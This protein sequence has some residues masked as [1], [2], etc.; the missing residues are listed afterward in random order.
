MSRLV[1][2]LASG[3]VHYAW[4][5][6]GVA[7]LTL[8]VAAGI[9]NAPTVL[10]LPLEHEFG[11]SATL[12]SLPVSVGLLLYGAVGPFSA[13]LIDRF[14]FRRVMLSALGLTTVGFGL[15][16]FVSKPWQ[17]L[18]LW[19][20]LTGAGTG[21]TALVMGAVVANRWFLARRGLVIGLLT[22]SAAAGQLLFV[23]PLDLLGGALGWRA[24]V[25]IA[26]L[27]PL[28][29]VP[30]VA[31]LMRDHPGDVGLAP[32]GDAGPAAAPAKPL[33]NPLGAVL[34]ALG[35]ALPSRDFWLLAASFFVCGGTT[36]GLVGTH[37]I[38]ACFDHGIAPSTAAT[39]IVA[40]G[41]CNI[42]GT[43]AS[44]WL[45][46]RFD[47]R[48][49]L[50]WY[51]LLR[52]FSLLFLPYAL[53]LSTVG[54]SLFGLFY[55]LDWIATVPPTVRLAANIF[56]ARQAGMIYG[57][58]TVVH[59]VGSALAASGAALVRDWRGD[60][61]DAFLIAGGFCFAAALLVLRLGTASRG[62][63]R[64]VLAEAGD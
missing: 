9:R 8:L 45:S 56:G 63:T 26:C 1:A 24:A 48:Y 10:L 54:M 43:T 59:Q 27:L 57:W 60:Y 36:I 52:G 16:P 31:L 29:M 61:G 35:R 4:I 51:Y 17:L 14:G 25:L 40:M 2:K 39:L 7:F 41:V 23:K 30:V 13:G 46:D 64:P 42:I 3:P 34:A 44:G 33:A 20:V 15:T 28:A 49:L 32:Y 58:I 37:F 19:G 22:A 53:D 47:S 18:V 50:F 5:V 21:L 12:V 38:A 55:G 11:W 6:A 62:A